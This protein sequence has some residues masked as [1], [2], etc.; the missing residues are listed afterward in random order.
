MTD[1][2]NVAMRDYWNSVAGPRWVGLAEVMEERTRAVNDL[3]LQKAA[4]RPGERVLDIGCGTG[5][6]TLP[7]AEAVGDTGHVLG[8]DISEPMMSRARERV[9]N[10]GRHNVTLLLAD[11]QTHQFAPGGID[12]FVSRFGVMF[13]EDPYAAFANL[14][15]AV[16]PGGRLCFVCWAPLAEN[17]H[18]LIPYEVALRHLG[19]PAPQPP[20]SPGPMAFADRDYLRDILEKAGFAEIAID[21]E[22]PPVLGASAELEAERACIM[23]PTARLLDEKKPDEAVRQKILEEATAAFRRFSATEPMTLPSTVYLVTARTL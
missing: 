15:R 11:A 13:F 10:S 1:A 19:P 12:L 9:A 22:T 2:G 16:R 7:L 23:G 14:R 20:R 17:R 21:R 5:A 3:L 18:W 4:A 8:V 6:T